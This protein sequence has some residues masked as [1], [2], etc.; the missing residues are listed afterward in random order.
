MAMAIRIGVVGLGQVARARH[1]PAIAANPAF[2][3]AGLASLGGGPDVAGLHVHADHRAML[4]SCALDAVAICTPP[5]AR[6][7]VARDALCAGLHVLLE[8][9]PAATLGEAEALVALAARKG[10]VLFATWHSQCNEAVEAAR[11]FLA[12][13]RLAALQVDWNEDF[14]KFHPDQEWIWQADGLGVFDM[15]INALSVVTRILGD[16]PFLRAAELRVAQGHGAPLSAVLQLGQAGGDAPME[17]RMDWAHRG[18]HQRE[19]RATTA[20]GHRLEL[21]ESGARLVIDGAVAVDEERAEYKLVYRR[22]AALVRE[23]R[24]EA[25]LA[26]LRLALDALATGRRVALPRQDL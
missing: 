5:A 1:L 24:S 18:P 23:G 16:P 20:C 6:F 19:L 2:T 26:P 14:R 12:G 13:R 11:R 22:F 7:E 10:R 3:L 4:A 25:D 9:P 15:G 21:L 17:I 8:K